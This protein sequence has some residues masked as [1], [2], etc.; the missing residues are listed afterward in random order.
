MTR[1]KSKY[2]KLTE[3]EAEVMEQLWE[4]GEL[5]VRQLLEA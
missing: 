1:T 2:P 3:R 4:R 5:T